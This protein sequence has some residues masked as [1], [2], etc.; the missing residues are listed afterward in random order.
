MKKE[1]LFKIFVVLIFFSALFLFEKSKI[2]TYEKFIHQLISED[3]EVIEIKISNW[4]F[5]Q[6]RVFH[7]TIKDQKMIEKIISEPSI[8]LKKVKD[9][10][11]AANSLFKNNLYIKTK[12]QENVFSF[13]ENYIHHGVTDYKVI[14]NKDGANDLYEYIQNADLEWTEDE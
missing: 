4:S 10:M 14:L 8:R 7:T 12:N 9:D 3:E 2:I 11:Q 6:E 13:S 5:M 1:L